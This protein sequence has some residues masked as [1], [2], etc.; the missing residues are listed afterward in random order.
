LGQGHSGSRVK[1]L[2]KERKLVKDRN[3]T[4]INWQRFILVEID[5]RSI[6][7]FLDDFVPCIIVAS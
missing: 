4:E 6:E 5:M 1:I 7:G 2:V 3:Q